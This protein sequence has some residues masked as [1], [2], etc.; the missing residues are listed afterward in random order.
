MAANIE[1]QPSQ[2]QKFSR[3]RSVR[4]AANAKLDETVP[5]LPPAHH[6]SPPKSDAIARSMSRYHRHRTSTGP[7][8]PPPLPTQQT[9]RTPAIDNPF[10]TPPRSRRAYDS[11]SSPAVSNRRSG[12]RD[13]GRAR[14]AAEPNRQEE[15][16]QMK[17]AGRQETRSWAEI[18]GARDQTKTEELRNDEGSEFRSRERE[19]R[20][21]W[22]DGLERIQPTARQ[23]IEERAEMRSRSNPALSNGLAQGPPPG[24]QSKVTSPVKERPG[25]WAKTRSKTGLPS[26]SRKGDGEKTSYNDQLIDPNGG[27]G[28]DVAVGVDAPISAVNAGERVSCCH[29]YSLNRPNNQPRGSQ[30]AANTH[31]LISL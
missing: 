2:A 13:E 20:N 29:V 28:A 15:E 30:Y 16:E 19:R 6:V 9:R 22:V 21:R 25:F 1:T 11:D 5:P 23:T 14:P 26:A 17:E 24:D 27:G 10:K 7:G 3:Y 8:A 31:L 18:E 12:G 4:K